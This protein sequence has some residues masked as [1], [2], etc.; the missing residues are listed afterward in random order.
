MFADGVALGPPLAGTSATLVDPR[1]LL[2]GTARLTFEVRDVTGAL[3]RSGSAGTITTGRLGTRVAVSTDL[4]APVSG[5]VGIVV[6]G[7]R[8]DGDTAGNMR[9]EVRVNGRN[10]GASTR[11]YAGGTWSDTITV[12][13]T[14]LADGAHEVWVTAECVEPYA[15]D[16]PWDGN[17]ARAFLRTTLTTANGATLRGLRAAYDH[18]ALV[19][20]GATQALSVA[21]LT[22]AGTR[23]VLADQTAP[24][25]ASSVPSVAT[26][27]GAGVV[28]PV[29]AGFTVV[30]VTYSGKTLTVPV[31][32]RATATDRP[33]FG[34]NASLQT[35][36][37][38]AST[39]PRAM[40]WIDLTQFGAADSA[41][42][43]ALGR[44]LRD[45]GINS[46]AM[47][48]M[49][50]TG[51]TEA[52]MNA[53]TDAL[54]A[55]AKG[56]RDR[57]GLHIHLIGD[58][59]LRTRA[60]FHKILNNAYA[61]AAV[62]YAHAAWAAVT[63]VT[64]IEYVD[65]VDL[66]LGN[67]ATPSDGRW[68]TGGTH[69]TAPY[70]MPDT[71]VIDF[72]GYARGGLAAPPGAFPTLANTGSGPALSW[73]GPSAGISDFATH[74][75]VYEPGDDTRARHD[76]VTHEQTV[77][78]RD[79]WLA[80]RFAAGMAP[81]E[82]WNALVSVMGR[83]VIKRGP[84]DHYR[85]SQDD[86]W[87]E[88][89]ERA[90]HVPVDALHALAM[91]AAGL[92]YYAYAFA[93]N[94]RTF[95]E[96]GALPGGALETA[97]HPKS[98]N[99]LQWCAMAAVNSLIAQLE[100]QLLGVR[101]HAPD[102][103]PEVTS[104]ARTSAA[105]DVQW[106]VN[107]A[108]RAHTVAFAPMPNWP[109]GG[110]A[111][112]WRVRG[113]QTDCAYE[114][115]ATHAHTFAIG[116]GTVYEL[117]ASGDERPAITWAQPIVPHRTAADVVL[118]VVPNGP[119]AP[120][121]VEYFVDGTSVG[122]VDAGDGWSLTVTRAAWALRSDAVYGEWVTLAAVATAADATTCEI[123]TAVQFEF[124]TTADPVA[125]AGG[126]YAN[127]PGIATALSSAGSTGDGLSYLWDFPV[128][129][130]IDGGTVDSTGKASPSAVFA[131]EGEYAVTLTVIDTRGRTDTDTVTVT[132]AERVEPAL[133][134]LPVTS[135]LVVWSLA[136]NGVTRDLDNKVTAWV[137]QM[138]PTGTTWQ[139]DADLV[140]AYVTREVDATTGRPV[141]RPAANYGNLSLAGPWTVG[142]VVVLG[143]HDGATFVNWECL[144]ALE[145]VGG[146]PKYPFYGWYADDRWIDDADTF[147]DYY[148]DGSNGTPNDHDI[149]NLGAHQVWAGRRTG[150]AWTGGG[151]LRLSYG[152]GFTTR[153]FHGYIE[154]V[155]VY[156]DVKT[157][158]EIATICADLLTRKPA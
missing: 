153:G 113:M 130:T 47:A 76:G 88:G 71:A 92:R 54:I 28:T 44:Y 64:Y 100:P 109:V 107:R 105:G 120:V 34:T 116:E 156:S 158:A 66:V 74:Y 7:T 84:G 140:N 57:Q 6:A 21:T 139:P 48:M 79:H 1:D 138:D 110:G 69:Y 97:A 55:R 40:F 13:T 41:E 122:T 73:Q 11:P 141:L 151:P 154:E 128:D 77:R 95:R 90:E 45:A 111:M 59:M 52:E 15:S 36:V 125:D 29:A 104:A 10:V 43:H 145:D 20:G 56:I 60:N 8:S 126:P 155:L 136:S 142:T 102:A 39:L 150:G 58:E 146:S 30:T 75:N 117:V 124:P 86:T 22:C 67:D 38:A 27:S 61:Q 65:E 53:D 83:F 127:E 81:E 147:D 49:D 63:G 148:V 62:Q 112:R 103:G 131:N 46:F 137:N 94:L 132:V 119:K 16:S 19:V 5:S 123:R 25:Y 106:F 93:S 33:H 51:T 42:E 89:Q 135:G 18:L 118:T 12:D 133:P 50:M 157:P 121:S 31:Y 9:F 70:P 32:V 26:V 96:S 99:T 2:N 68:D 115:D 3:V 35:T 85:R 143:K 114:A 72:L 101:R 108:E 98:C 152:P 23:T 14:T 4:T 24:A 87:V 80:E 78:G 144:M 82:A 129:V 17:K 149:P 37:G 134:T 91:G